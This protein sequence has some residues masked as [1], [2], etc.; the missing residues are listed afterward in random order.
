MA[1]P[2]NYSVTLSK[3]VEGELVDISGPQS[4][5]LKPLYSG[6]LV[7]ENRQAVLDFQVQTAELYR[8]VTGPGGK[9]T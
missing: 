3:R 4:F 1:L 2:G 7:A 6:G 9:G 5:A 8:A